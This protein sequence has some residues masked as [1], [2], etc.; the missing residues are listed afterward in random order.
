MNQGSKRQALV[1]SL[2]RSAPEMRS[3]LSG[4]KR[5]ENDVLNSFLPRT[6]VE[7]Y[8]SYLLRTRCLWPL[9]LRDISWRNRHLRLKIAPE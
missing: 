2:K 4:L 1:D 9:L 8:P 7:P 5:W 6:G 3:Y